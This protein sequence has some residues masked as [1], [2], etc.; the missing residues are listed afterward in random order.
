MFLARDLARLPARRPKTT[1]LQIPLQSN[2]GRYDH[3]GPTRLINCYAE[4]AGKEGKIEW[5]VYAADGLKSFATLTSGGQCRGLHDLTTEGLAV[6]ARQLYSVD[7]SGSATTKGGIPGDGFV[8]FATNRATPKETAIATEDGNV[9]S[10]IAGV[11]SPITDTDLQPPNSVDFLD[12]Y[13]LYFVTN[14]RVYYSEI[15]DATNIGANSF[16]TAE[17]SNDSLVRGIVHNRTIFLLGTET[18]ERWWNDGTTP[19]AR[20][21]G[22]FHEIGCASGASVAKSVNEVIF[23]SNKGGVMAMSQSG[24]IRKIS[25]HAVDRDIASISDKTTIEAFID[26]RNGVEFYYLSAAT[27]TWV[28]DLSTGLWHERS[29]VNENRW[30]GA[31]YMAF[32]GKRIVG[33]YNS[34]VLLELGPDT[35]TENS[36][37][38]IMTVRFPVHAWPEPVSLKTLDVDMIPGV[39]LNDSDLHLSDPQLMMRV[40]KNGGKTWGDEATRSI[41]KI[42]QHTQTTSFNKNDFG[43][44]FSDG[45]VIELKASAAVIRAI[46]GVS[47]E[48]EIKRR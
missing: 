19:F 27:F 3:D 43:T 16:F 17:G 23:V 37:N 47:G 26:D 13:T 6:S 46:T 35:Y 20:V 8:T 48:P 41:G 4:R 14:G 45:Y 7:P 11:L 12:G 36:G 24:G 10:Y 34:G 18:T 9:F 39:G 25:T 44:S 32:A 22:G 21:P 15:D 42:G 5:P 29:S 31:Q 30:I 28:C 2:P 38:M 33:H 40:S 1:P